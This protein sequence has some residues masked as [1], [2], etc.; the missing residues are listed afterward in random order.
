M[1]KSL[2]ENNVDKL[3]KATNIETTYKGVLSFLVQKSFVGKDPETI[4]NI[5]D[6]FLSPKNMKQMVQIIKKVY[7]DNYIPSEIV[8]MLKFYGSKDGKSVIEKSPRLASEI[9]SQLKVWT[10]DITSEIMEKIDAIINGQ[11]VSEEKT[12]ADDKVFIVDP[13]EITLARYDFSNNYIKEKGWDYYNLTPDQVKEIHAQ[14]GWKNAK[15]K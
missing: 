8:T 7:M 10:E 4:Q 6:V 9:A 15:K 3:I 14:D 11:I 1:K 12:K 13:E 5:I 2:F